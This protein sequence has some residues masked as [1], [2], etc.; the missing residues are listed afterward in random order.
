MHSFNDD[1]IMFES[2]EDQLR[3]DFNKDIIKDVKK[4]RELLKEFD[5]SVPG[6]DYYVAIYKLNFDKKYN[7]LVI[8]TG[9]YVKNVEK[10][11]KSEK[12]AW[13]LYYSMVR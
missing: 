11:F 12:K 3:I 9:T 6:R 7:F 13:E 5:G 8:V 1:N 4:E 10:Y 2:F